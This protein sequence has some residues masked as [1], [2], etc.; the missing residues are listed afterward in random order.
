MPVRVY[1]YKTFFFILLLSTDSKNVCH[2]R[3][4]YFC[5]S[6]SSSGTTNSCPTGSYCP[7]QSSSS[8]L[9]PAG[10][11]GSTLRLTTSSCSGLCTYGP[12][13]LSLS[14]RSLPVVVGMKSIMLLVF[15]NSAG[16]YC[17][18]GSVSATQNPCAVHMQYIAHF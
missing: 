2:A 4:G 6:C 18:A 13:F 9:C 12:L 14:D 5:P 16:Y 11:F 3:A 7:Q 10:K 15:S 17:N 1:Y 8:T